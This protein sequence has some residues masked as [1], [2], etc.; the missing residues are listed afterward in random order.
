M[1]KTGDRQQQ[2]E[3]GFGARLRRLSA[4]M[5]FHAALLAALVALPSSWA[6]VFEKCELARELLYV[7][8]FPEDQIPQWVCIAEHESLFNSSAVGHMNWDGSADHG[9]FQINDR[10]WCSPPGPK[11]ECYID[12]AGNARNCIPQKRVKNV[13]SSDSCHEVRLHLLRMA[14]EKDIKD[15]T[16]K[17]WRE[18]LTPDQFYI[19]RQRGTE[20]AYRGRWVNHKAKGTYTC[21]ACGADLFRLANMLW[22][23]KAMYTYPNSTSVRWEAALRSSLLADQLWAVQQAHGATDRLGLTVPTRESPAAR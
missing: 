22:E 7:H 4:K 17:D 19:C 21:I 13:D 14:D 23:C 8:G 1:D 15:M 2:Q 12:C 5:L 10:Y 3:D 16:E 6:K 11:N 20:P 18:K 9:L